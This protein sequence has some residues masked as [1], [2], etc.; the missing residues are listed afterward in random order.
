MSRADAV[1]ALSKAEANFQQRNYQLA[2]AMHTVIP[3]GIDATN[4]TYAR[5]N[6]AGKGRPWQLLYVG[7]LIALKNVD[8]LLRA[9]ARIRAAS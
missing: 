6:A 3:N 8:V 1:V 9:L 7:Q 5:N 2:G 4:Y